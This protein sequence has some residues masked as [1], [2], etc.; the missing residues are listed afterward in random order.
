MRFCV[1]CQSDISV[2]TLVRARW[3]AIF[4]SPQCREADK[5][6]IRIARKAY[7]QEKGLCP[8]CGHKPS[9]ARGKTLGKLSVDDTGGKNRQIAG[10]DLGQNVFRS[11]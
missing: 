2:E 5:S 1:H 11:L 3:K 10:N 7:R 6:M 8:T 4:C 9:N